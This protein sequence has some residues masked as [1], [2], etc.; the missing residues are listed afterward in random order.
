MKKEETSLDDAMKL[1]E[2]IQDKCQLHKAL[3]I[4]IGAIHYQFNDL[5]NEGKTAKEKDLNY[6]PIL[7]E[8]SVEVTN[9]ID[10]L[11]EKLSEIIFN[12]KHE[13]QS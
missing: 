1:S 6:I 11:T 2:Q 8:L 13:N 9:A 3:S 7:V 10:S 12:L 4:A 5:T